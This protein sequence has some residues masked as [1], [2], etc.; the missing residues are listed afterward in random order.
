MTRLGVIVVHYRTPNDLRLALQ[1][2]RFQGQPLQVVVV[3][4]SE[5]PQVRSWFHVAVEW[6]GDVRLVERPDNPG[7]GAACHAGWSALNEDVDPVCIANADVVFPPGALQN[8]AAFM[9]T[10]PDA[11]AAGPRIQSPDGLI[12]PSWGAP[13]TFGREFLY[14]WRTRWMH[15][16]WLQ[17]RWRRSSEPRPVTW[18]SGAC[19]MVRRAAW[20]AVGGLDAGFFMY[21]EDCDFGLRLNQAGWKVWWVPTV[22]VIHFRGQSVS[23]NP[24]VRTRV[25]QARR[26]AQWRY[27]RK[28]RPAWERWL[29][30]AY[31]MLRGIRIEGVTEGRVKEGEESEEEK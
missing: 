15:L 25:R 2:L 13:I 19:M 8:L 1:S 28:H 4:A 23:R 26:A 7:F 12:E 22:R 24:Q 10:Q 9:T 14:R 29:L 17:A 31:F 30:R 20:E 6:L 11:G 5:E 18:V 21:Y 3:D 16:P 27:Y